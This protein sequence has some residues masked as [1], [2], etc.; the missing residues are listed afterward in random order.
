[1]HQVVGVV[2]TTIKM[3]TPL[4]AAGLYG[5]PSTHAGVAPAATIN[6][7]EHPALNAKY[8]HYTWIGTKIGTDTRKTLTGPV[9]KSASRI[10]MKS[11]PPAISGGYLGTEV[12][13]TCGSGWLSVG[14]ANEAQKTTRNS[15]PL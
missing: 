5:T 9:V 4:A 7:S 12:S 8:V 2:M 10:E 13:T 15:W 1:M 6:G 14:F 11:V 3:N